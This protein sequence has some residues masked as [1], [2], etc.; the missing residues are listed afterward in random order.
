M[1][2]TLYSTFGQIGDWRITDSTLSSVDE[3]VVLDSVNS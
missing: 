1:D 3:D 2:G